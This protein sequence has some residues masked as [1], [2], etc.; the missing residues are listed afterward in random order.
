MN[1]YICI[2]QVERGIQV[3]LILLLHSIFSSLFHVRPI[4]FLIL[5]TFKI[6]IYHNFP[7]LLLLPFH[8]LPFW[9][10]FSLFFIYLYSYSYIDWC[11]WMW[12]H[13]IVIVIYSNFFHSILILGMPFVTAWMEWENIILSETSQLVKDV[14]HMISP[15]KE[16]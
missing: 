14:Y 15:V 6:L 1:I 11:V 10:D 5:F 3:E 13:C 4:L 7:L 9:C 2:F 12:I 8:G 16:I